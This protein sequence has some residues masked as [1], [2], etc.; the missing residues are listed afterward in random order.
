MTTL[1]WAGDPGELERPM[2]EELE[3]F[4]HWSGVHDGINVELS[5]PTGLRLTVHVNDF[6]AVDTVIG[7]P[8]PPG[9]PAYLEER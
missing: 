9:W 5:V 2:P 7:D 1:G 8:I 4:A 3:C 6:T